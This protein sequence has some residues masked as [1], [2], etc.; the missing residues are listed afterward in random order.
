MNKYTNKISMFLCM[1]ALVL[2]AASCSE[3]DDI[4]SSVKYDRLFSPTDLGTRVRNRTGVEISWSTRNAKGTKYTIEVATDESFSS[5][6]RTETTEA[7]PYF[8]FGLDGETEYFIR[9][10]ASADG[11]AESKWSPIAKFTTD[12]EN[13]YLPLKDGDLQATTVTLR[14]TEGETVEKIEVLDE[15]GALVKTQTVSAEESAA[16]AATVT[17][18]KGETTYTFVLKRN[19][20]TRGSIKFT[21]EL[22]LAG[23]IKV[24]ADDDWYS[25]LQ[26]GQDGDV[27]AF[28][29]GEYAAYATDGG[30]AFSGIT[31]SKS[32]SIKA[33]K[34]TDKPV[35]SGFNFKLEAGVSLDLL[36]VVFDG[37]KHSDQFIVYGAAGDID[38]LN[39]S[40]CEISNYV[41][42]FFY[43]NVAAVINEI[44]IDNCLIHDIVCDGGDFFDSRKGGYNAFNL[45]NTTI[46]R[47]AAKR[48]VFRYDD[49]SGSV[50]AASV[51]KV[52]HCTFAEVGNGGANYRIFYVRFKGNSI[53]FT[54]NVVADFN[55]ARGFSEQKNTAVPTFEGNYY[56]NTQN[57]VKI[58]DGNTQAIQ[59]FDSKGTVLSESPFKNAAEADYTVINEDVAYEKAGDPRWIK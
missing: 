59:F 13:I 11:I 43:L 36:N 2:G 31:L 51:I 41:K 4:I 30:T 15:T 24:T 18:L 57:L 25:I 53:S 55:N 50:T 33:A 6:V 52:D 22:D 1:G 7:S 40:G 8:F 39:I 56:F 44:N 34:S 46:Y 17:D 35:F 14:W 26:A 3:P 10:K 42:G 49:A 12:T 23:A 9:I 45:T 5:I 28:M 19:G 32:I 54:N 21:T 47:S 38:H 16:G 58:A 27:F 29:P 37:N 48:D 20:K